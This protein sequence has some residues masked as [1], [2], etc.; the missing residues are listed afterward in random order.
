MQRADLPAKHLNTKDL[1]LKLNKASSLLKNCNQME[2][3]TSRRVIFTNGQKK[4]NNISVKFS[5]FPSGKTAEDDS[6]V[7]AAKEVFLALY[8]IP[9][10]TKESPSSSSTSLGDNSIKGSN[11]NNNTQTPDV[12]GNGDSRGHT[13][14]HKESTPMSAKT[15]HGRTFKSTDIRNV[16]MDD[17][18]DKLCQD[19]EM[20]SQREINHTNRVKEELKKMILGNGANA[21]V[22]G[23]QSTMMTRLKSR[24]K[25]YNCHPCKAT[26]PKVLDETSPLTILLQLYGINKRR[27]LEHIKASS[28]SDHLGW[29]GAGIGKLTSAFCQL[30]A[31]V[32]SP[33]IV[34]ANCGYVDLARGAEIEDV[35][36]SFQHLEACL[37]DIGKAHGNTNER[38]N[39]LSISCICPGPELLHWENSKKN[40]FSSSITSRGVA[41]SSLNQWII[42]LNE[43][44]KEYANGVLRI[45]T[46]TVKKRKFIDPETSEVLPTFSID[47]RK[48]RPSEP[49]AKKFHLSD[50]VAKGIYIR[51][52]DFLRKAQVHKLAAI[53]AENGQEEE[54]DLDRED[55]SEYDFLL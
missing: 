54:E 26:H 38:R 36:A 9:K 50:E 1:R 37:A 42:N 5:N 15:K 8:K 41:I 31:N 3:M 35:K 53:A 32:R 13:T 47:M 4:N 25:T 7:Q 24:G 20:A 45:H 11:S 28:H 51:H 43:R 30:Y 21:N 39:T 29:P 23:I 33:L 6:T 17:S 22:N 34:V 48:F 2:D 55:L 10:L 52:L 12:E 16:I 44:N 18:F 19:I 40:K 46:L 49:D 27:G 14:T